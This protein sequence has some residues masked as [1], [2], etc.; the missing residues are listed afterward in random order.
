VTAPIGPSLSACSLAVLDGLAAAKLE[1]G[2]PDAWELIGR[3]PDPDQL[4]R[5]PNSKITAILAR[6]RR[7]KRRC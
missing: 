1:L 2:D 4:A 7:R 3:S 6:N 5:L